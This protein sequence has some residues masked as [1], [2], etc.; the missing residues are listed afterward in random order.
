MLYQQIIHVVCH[1][2][3][4]MAAYERFYIVHVAICIVIQQG[5]KTSGKQIT[6]ATVEY[7]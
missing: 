2:K 1:C 4:Q 5:E 6:V 7:R 3:E